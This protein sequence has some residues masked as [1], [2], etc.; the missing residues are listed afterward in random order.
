[1]VLQQAVDA[2]IA[3]GDSEVEIPQGDY[4]FGA[5]AFVIRGASNLHVH[6]HGSGPR[7]SSL[8]FAPGYGLEVL[9]CNN[10][11][12]E[13]ISTDNL[14]PPNSQGTLL[15]MN[16]TD[17]TIIVRVDPGFPLLDTPLFNI[18]WAR[19]CPGQCVGPYSVETKVV[20]WDAHQRR[21]MW[22]R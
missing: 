11:T 13:G 16:L 22:V 10:V 18:T 1:M 14:I 9:T 3:A 6:G 4:N 21:I 2:A 7:G 8:W 5:L 17:N 12:V 20:Y 19:T 15:S